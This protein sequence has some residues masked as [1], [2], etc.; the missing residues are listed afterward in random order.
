MPGVYCQWRENRKDL[1]LEHAKDTC[2]LRRVKVINARE[3]KAGGGET[4]HDRRLEHLVG[5]V[6]AGECT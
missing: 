1:L 2:L 4:G 6:P 5:H 3:V